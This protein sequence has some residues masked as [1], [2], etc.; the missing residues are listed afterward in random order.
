MAYVLREIN[1][2][3]ERFEVIF[4]RDLIRFR[5]CQYIVVKTK[6]M[7][8][9]ETS[10]RTYIGAPVLLITIDRTATIFLKNFSIV[11]VPF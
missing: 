11:C 9:F 1:R 4:T 8:F 3:D 6:D 2:I 5:L 7:F 10:V